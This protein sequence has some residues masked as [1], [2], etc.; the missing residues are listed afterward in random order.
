M[1]ILIAEDEQRARQGLRKLISSMSEAYEIVAEAADGKRALELMQVVKPEVVFTDIKM[2]YMN[3]IAL[4]K[5][6]HSMGIQARF[7]ITSAYE[8]FETARQAIS[9]GVTEYL[10]KP[11]MYDEVEEVMKRLELLLKNEQWIPD[12]DIVKKYPDAHPLVAKVLKIIGHSYATKLNQEE[13]AK[14]LSVTPEYLSYI[15]HK[16]VGERFSKFLRAYRI[17]VAKTLLLQDGMIKEEIPYAV[18]FSDPK[19]F[20]KV[21]REVVGETITEFLKNMKKY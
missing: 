14:S 17:E 3:G 2:P 1:R 18:G 4:I 16:D 13:I 20:N 19:Y 7:V 11:I 8:E 10:V 12:L 21:F 5:A 15:F 9:L 6:A